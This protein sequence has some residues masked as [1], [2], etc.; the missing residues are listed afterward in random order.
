MKADRRKP[1]ALP[2]SSCG[3]LR[4]T[5]ECPQLMG[6]HTTPSELLRFHQGE[7]QSS[8]ADGKPPSAHKEACHKDM[9]Q[10]CADEGQL[11]RRQEA[12]Q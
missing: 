7:L 8:R 3:V 2:G 10:G 6:H 9:S 1:T 12:P 4:T 11:P 5:V